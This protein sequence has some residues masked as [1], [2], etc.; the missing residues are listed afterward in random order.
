MWL[1]N[2]CEQCL[3]R[4]PSAHSP[5]TWPMAAGDVIPHPDFVSQSPGGRT[6]IIYRSEDAFSI[7]DLHLI[8]NLAVQAPCEQDGS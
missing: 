1:R 7:V 8:T 4:C 6:I 2:D 5:F 3:K